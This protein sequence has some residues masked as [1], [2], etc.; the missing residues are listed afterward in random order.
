[1]KILN[2]YINKIALIL[3]IL[4]P[5]FAFFGNALIEISISTIAILFLLRSFI[6][7]D[8]MWLRYTWVKFALIFWCYTIVRGLFASDTWLATSTAFVY[9]RFMLLAVA[10]AYW[11]SHLN[12]SKRYFVLSSLISLLI[13]IANSLMQYSLGYDIFGNTIDYPS[14]PRL[15]TPIG[16]PSVGM[17][18]CMLAFPAAAY[19]LHSLIK[20]QSPLY[21]KISAIIFIMFIVITIFVSGERTAFF[22][23]IT[24]LILLIILEPYLRKTFLYICGACLLGLIIFS[25]YNNAVV[26]RQFDRT[27]S[28]IYSFEHSSYGRIYS[29]GLKLFSEHPLFGVGTRN[30]RIEC[31]EENKQKVQCSLHPHS[32]YLE[33]LIEAGMIGSLLFFTLIILWLRDL[34]VCR[35]TIQANFVSWGAT[36]SVLIKLLPFFPSASLYAAWAF[37]PFWLMLGWVYSS[38]WKKVKPA[39]H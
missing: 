2:L 7:Q 8:L 18:M 20:K 36:I 35:K 32:I 17:I 25:L 23:F 39:V 13:I 27:Y 26:V 16:K 28:E 34:Y 24:G 22:S 31:K 37:A 38:I 1:M 33:M 5:F 11:I 30:Y 9:L 21:K 10:I 29:Q 14:Y 19:L 12:N 4:F 15:F 6:N 3:V